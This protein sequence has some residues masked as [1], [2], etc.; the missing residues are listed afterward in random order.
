MLLSTQLAIC[1][2]TVQCS[3]VLCYGVKV[4]ARAGAIRRPLFLFLLLFVLLLMRVFL[5]S[6]STRDAAGT[7]LPMLFHKKKKKVTPPTSPGN[8]MITFSILFILYILFIVKCYF[9]FAGFFPSHNVILKNILGGRKIL[10][11]YFIL[12]F[13]KT[14]E[15]YGL[16]WKDVSFRNAR[17]GRPCYR[18]GRQ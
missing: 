5:P 2:V 13:I 7:T 17:V 18:P 10:I 4:V 16:Q 12:I 11:L 15:L 14:D 3:A 6:S 1:G 8:G 9:T